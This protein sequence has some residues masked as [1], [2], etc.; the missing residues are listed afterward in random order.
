ML[1]LYLVLPVVGLGLGFGLKSVLDTSDILLYTTVPCVVIWIIGCY[2][3]SYCVFGRILRFE[4]PSRQYG[5]TWPYTFECG[6]MGMILLFLLFGWW[7]VLFPCTTDASN[8]YHVITIAYGFFMLVVVG[9]IWW[10][11]RTDPSD[12]AGM[13]HQ[14]VEN[15]EAKHQWCIFCSA[16]AKLEKYDGPW[17]RL[18]EK[19]GNGTKVTDCYYS[20]TRRRHC[21]SCQKCVGGFDHH[22]YY[23]NTC[24]CDN[25]YT[26]FVIMLVCLF[27]MIFTEFVYCVMV[28]TNHF[29]NDNVRGTFGGVLDN[30][31]HIQ[32][33]VYGQGLFITLVFIIVFVSA[34]AMWFLA[35]L[36]YL[37][38][39]FI[40]RTIRSD[41]GS[42]RFTTLDYLHEQ[43]KKKM[44]QAIEAAR[45]K[46]GDND[47]AAADIQEQHDFYNY[48]RANYQYH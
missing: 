46:Y 25:N 9:L 45:A 30:Q 11:V 27:C 15:S 2:L 23:L 32:D 39:Y 8:S 17:R 28:L 14:K 43:R 10:I 35:D 5:Y 16:R 24:I 26:Q 4:R 36:L 12:D 48:N 47:L 40:Y 42:A 13:S 38:F 1:F 29:D 44:S 31:Q 22:C 37:H 33:D 34:Y 7:G 21:Q 41:A 6:F 19:I 3:F 20:Y 18:E